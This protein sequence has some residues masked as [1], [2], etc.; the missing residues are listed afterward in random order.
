MTKLRFGV[1]LDG[2]SL[3][4]WQ[5]E[6]LRMLL[7]TGLA[8][9]GL[10]VVNG[11][12][13]TAAEP[14]GG[15]LPYLREKARN[16]YHPERYYWAY[17]AE[18]RACY[19]VAEDA[20]EPC[21]VSA[22]LRVAPVLT[23]LPRQTLFSD[24]FSDAEV[25]AVREHDLDFIV[26]FGFRIIRGDILEAARY[27]VWSYHHG[28][29]ER[30]RGGPACFWEMLDGAP[31][32]GLILQ[33]LT[34]A[35]DGG[36]VLYKSQGRT[37]DYSLKL[38][39][40]ALAWKGVPFLARVARRVADEG[41]EATVE[42]AGKTYGE[43]RP[44]PIY[45]TP[46][47]ADLMRYLRLRRDRIAA[48]PERSVT[49]WNVWLRRTEGPGTAA[50]DASGFVMIPNPPG[51]FLADPHLYSH[52]GRTALFVEDFDYA[53]GRGRISCLSLSEEGA[54]APVPVIERPYHLSG[55]FIIE[56]DG[57]L[58]L[59]PETAENRTI[60]AYRC[61]E[62]PTRWEYAGPL[63]EGVDAV[64]PKMYLREGKLWLFVGTR[65]PHGSY[66][67]ELSVFF[68]DDL[69]GPWTPCAGNPVVSDVRTARP[70]GE[71][72]EQDG[73]LIRPSQDCSGTYGRRVNFMRVLELGEGAYR[74]EPHHVL[75]PEGFG[76]EGVHSYTRVPGFEAVDTKR[77]VPSDAPW[78][79]KRQSAYPFF[80]LP[81]NLLHS[82][83][84]W[85]MGAVTGRLF[86]G[87]KRSL[88]RY[89][90]AGRR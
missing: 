62:F 6:A 86:G 43:Q 42:H 64:D 69:F 1:M 50:A 75:A 60:E 22:L 33:R 41:W 35:L 39:I 38:N 77:G 90:A 17:V 89:A 30:Y 57:S 10:V 37:I 46:G 54:S 61:V 65:T 7:D 4:R 73:V 2:Y 55:P 51:R 72:F 28:D 71:L 45:R 26:R 9:L 24:Y 81:W 21:D 12:A 16:A 84:P 63:M 11:R 15:L 56:W 67:D 58:Y 85:S 68:A 78:A 88:L 59:L 18:D 5:A 23:A 19:E 34:E 79:A 44:G 70:A 14:D 52:K 27:G 74:E 53:S 40:N 83:L 3:C 49:E 76:A 31:A 82:L 36:V 66:D 25:S 47:K 13:G 87:L 20:A 32:T 29:N 8:E 80:P 48:Q